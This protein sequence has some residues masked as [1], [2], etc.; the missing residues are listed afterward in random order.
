V[1]DRVKAERERIAVLAEEHADELEK[2]AGTDPALIAGV[3]GGVVALRGFATEVRS[4]V[5]PFGPSTAATT[6]ASGP[7]RAPLESAE[8]RAREIGRILK[9]V[10]PDGWG[11]VVVLSSFEENG[12]T[13]YLSSI[14][15]EG[16][17][18]MLSKLLVSIRDEEPSL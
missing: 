7:K 3:L 1:S 16:A 8:V 15:R 11:F 4:G 14:A 9:R 5:N 6:R 18:T 10:M 13:T 17:V 2:H 12:F